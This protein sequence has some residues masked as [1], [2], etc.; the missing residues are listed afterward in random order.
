MS[1]HHNNKFPNR[2]GLLSILDARN[3]P[4]SNSHKLCPHATSDKM[5][6]LSAWTGILLASE[7]FWKKNN[8]QRN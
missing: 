5:L 8:L 7:T 4:K 2:L 6:T 1:Q 3:A